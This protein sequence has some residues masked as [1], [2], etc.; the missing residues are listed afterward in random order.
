MIA[1]WIKAGLLAVG[2]SGVAAGVALQNQ[3]PATWGQSVG[4]VP[5]DPANATLSAA[6][7]EWRSLL[8]T[9]NGPFDSYARFL[10]A[11]PG[12]PNDSQLRRAAEAALAKPGWSPSLA[13]AFFRRYPPQNATAWVRFAQGLAATGATSEAK[14]A[15]RTG[16]TMGAL[17][18]DDEALVLA[19]WSDALSPADHDLR[20]DQLLWQGQTSAAARQIL[21]TSAGRRPLFQARLD[22]RTSGSMA[23]S[24][25][26]IGAGDPGYLADKVAWLTSSGAAPS[27]RALLAQPHRFTSRPL[28]VDRWYDL[29]L[30]QARAAGTA[31]DYTTA[32]AIASQVDDA[33]P[34]G[35]DVSLRPYGERDPY[36]DLVW[37]AGQTAYKRLARPADAAAMFVRYTGGSRSTA[38]KAKGFYWAGRAAEA[39]GQANQARDYLARAATYRDQF[40]GQLASERL[41]LP[42]TAPTDAIDRPVD[43]AQRQAFYASEVVRAAQFLG[44]IGDHEGQ[45]AFVRRIADDATSPS[46]HA[47]AAELAKKIQRPDLAVMVGRSALLNG[48][49]DYTLTGFPTFNVPPSV[50][51]GWSVAHGIMRQESQ[52]D[53]ALISRVGARG[54]MQLMPGT[55]REQATKLGLPWDQ[56]ML[57]TS[58]DYNIQLGTAYFQRLYNLYGS[59]PLAIAA[60]NAGGGNVNKW[61]A[62]NGDP[63]TGA[64]DWIDWIEAIPFDET[65]RYVQHVLENAVVY[66][67]INPARATSVG[68]ARLSWYIGNKQPG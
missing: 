65:K 17:S 66:D 47:L 59:Y 24:A 62:A 50:V 36:T 55:A 3:A 44:A 35:T 46:D 15:A 18:P 10:V 31:G 12:W 13:V 2:A 63:R 27:A 51:T 49:S 6:I 48:V 21:L 57:L 28:D 38:L 45:S 61:L 8:Q 43:P 60:Y 23:G 11:H 42:L 33:Y 4:A 41:G 54:V 30:R 26:A 20:M 9:S 56:G 5:S 58:T 22:L 53:R 32:Y 25:D 68:P 29:L 52:F 39:A 1:P 14:N 37:L 34:A 7:T 16:W 64:V 67:L 19:N 40:Y